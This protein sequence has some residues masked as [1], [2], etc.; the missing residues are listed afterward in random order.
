MIEVEYVWWINRE[1]EM[2]FGYKKLWKLLID[3]DLKKCDL[4]NMC[5]ISKSTVAK[6]NQGQ[7]VN[8]DILLRICK[9]LECELSDIVEI[10]ED[11]ESR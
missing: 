8:T 5:G 10:V 9:A 7:N 6:L 1:V 4:I 3:R 11:E 2:H